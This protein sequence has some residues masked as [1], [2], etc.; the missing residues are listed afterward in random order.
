MYRFQKNISISGME[1]IKSTRIKFE[2]PLEDLIVCIGAQ[3]TA[4]IPSSQ[5][6]SI[7]EKFLSF[8]TCKKV[9]NVNVI[10]CLICDL[11]HVNVLMDYSSS[12]FG[13]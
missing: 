9:K 13:S 4:K 6:C 1:I 7:F 11:S 8:K 10:F 12:F 2:S 3:I 5:K